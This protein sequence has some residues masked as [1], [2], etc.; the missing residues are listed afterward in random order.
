MPVRF[1]AKGHVALVTIDR[2]DARNAIDLETSRALTDAWFRFRDD[3]DL[4][5]AVLTGAGDRA[6]SAGL[7]LKKAAEYYGSVP[8][9]KRREVWDREPGLG[10]ITR[11]LDCGKPVIAAIRGHCLGGGLELALACDIRIASDDAKLALPEV[12][13]AFIPGQGGTQRLARLV[14]ASA[15]LEMILTGASVDARRALELGLVSLVVPAERLLPEALG[16]AEAIAK[17]PPRAVRFAREAVLRGLDGPLAE[18]LRIEQGLAELL[19]ESEDAKEARAAFA[20][21]RE[22]RWTGR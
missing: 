6:F 2:P 16:L 18:G 22:P 7:D 12:T 20:E 3:D 9:Q 21:K 14:G 17:N 13:H 8:A 4:R 1:E 10:G 5:C 19:R 15:A 11:N